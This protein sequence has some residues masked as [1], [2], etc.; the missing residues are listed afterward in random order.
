LFAALWLMFVSLLTTDSPSSLLQR[1][2]VEEARRAFN[3]VRL[4]HGLH[5]EQEWQGMVC[6]ADKIQF[7]K[8]ARKMKGGLPQQQQQG[9]QMS[10]RSSRAVDAINDTSHDIGSS[11]AQSSWIMLILQGKGPA[12]TAVASNDASPVDLTISLD[13]STH[14]VPAL[15]GQQQQQQQ[16]Q[17]DVDERPPRWPAYIITFHLTAM[18]CWNG[19]VAV[20]FFAAVLFSSTGN[21]VSMSLVAQ[22]L[23]GS[24]TV[25]GGFVAM[26]GI[27]KVRDRHS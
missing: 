18:R 19:Y 1:S 8:L 9:L 10:W 27:D 21:S 16:Q 17:W 20:M 24:C 4:H 13:Q 12:G 14:A 23:L 2:R 3:K 7:A 22:T 11:G 25:F 5:H 26:A 15:Q 6:E